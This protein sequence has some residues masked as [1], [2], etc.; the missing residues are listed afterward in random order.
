MSTAVLQRSVVE[1]ALLGWLLAQAPAVARLPVGLMTP[2]EVAAELQR[3]QA[4]TAMDA[5]YEAELVM[6][7]AAARPDTDDPPPGH[8]GARRRGGGSPVPGTS[9][10]LPDELAAV[11]NCARPFAAGVLSDA[12]QLVERMPAVHAECAAGRLDRY[13]ARVFADVLATASAEVVA[14]VVPAVL[15]LAAGLSAGKLRQRL[16]AAAEAAD[17]E[18][19]EQRRIEAQQRAAVRLY[20]TGEGMS[21]LASELPAPVAAAMWSVID[22]SAQL[23]ATGDDRPIGVLRAE[24]HAALVLQSGDPTRPAMT[25]HVTVVAPLPALHPPAHGNPPN[26]VDPPNPVDPVHQA[27]ARFAT[28]AEPPG[29]T[30]PPGVAEP[31]GAAEPPDLAHPPGLAQPPD[32]AD[33]PGA[34]RPSHFLPPADLAQPPDPAD[35]VERA[36]AGEA[37]PA[38]NGTPITAAH[39]RELLAQLGALGVQAPPGGSLTVAL[40]DDDGALLATTTPTELTRRA[41]RGCRMH[42]PDADCGCPVLGPPADVDG[43]AHSTAQQRFLRL[44]DRTCRHP[45]CGQPAGRTDADHVLPHDRGGPTSCHNLCCLCRTHHRLKTFARGWRSRMHRDGTLNVTTPTGI[46]RT[47]RPPGLREQPAPTTPAPEPP[48]AAEEP[49]PF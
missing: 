44:R 42:G 13:R 37:T 25:G 7:L 47:T 43:Y 45:G 22:Q 30:H 16:V 8:P 40:T 32:L 27:E 19:A 12:Y 29:V 46:T 36:A 11:L 33:A 26:L 10:F 41:A 18:F 24:A 38:V 6:A 14:A 3:V 2:E 21:V 28:P 15:P 17:E 49:P 20:P 34:A 35:Q 39:L 9:E 31:P 5:A 23:A 4:R 1:G 48:P